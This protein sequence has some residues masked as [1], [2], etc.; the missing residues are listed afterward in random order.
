MITCIKCNSEFENP[1]KS[2]G[3]SEEMVCPYCHSRIKVKWK[4]EMELA[5]DEPAEN[6]AS[7]IVESGKP[8]GMKVLVAV[9]GEATQDVMKEV[10]VGVGYEVLLASNGQEALSILEKEHPIVAYLDV[11]LPQVLG[12]EVCEIIKKSQRL[13]STKVILV[14]AI[15]DKTRYKRAPTSLYGADDYIERH[16]IQDGLLEKLDKLMNSKEKTSESLAE[17]SV[18]GTELQ[19][20]D[21]NS[22]G[23]GYESNNRDSQPESLAVVRPDTEPHEKKNPSEILEP[24]ANAPSELTIEAPAKDIPTTPGQGVLTDTSVE[25][26][27]KLLLTSEIEPELE[28][29]ELQFPTDNAAPEISPEEKLKHEEAKRFARLIISDIALYNQKEIEAGI[30]NGNVEEILKDEMAEAEKLFRDRVSKE[31][32][33][34]SNYLQ[35]ALRDLVDRKSKMMKHGD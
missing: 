13:K 23:F 3:K 18:A 25:E 14:S 10:L 27:A 26:P 34:N 30:E 1:I 9:D 5:A 17:S 24:M 29:K 16:H 2:N 20:G 4:M 8:K 7:G 15:Y 11:A 6:A 33:E 12:F 19:S 22:S 35:E 32:R 21:S 31:I 28:V